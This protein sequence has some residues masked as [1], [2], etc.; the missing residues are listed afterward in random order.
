M[1]TGSTYRRKE[2][3]RVQTA[4]QYVGD[5]EEHGPNSTHLEGIP[6]GFSGG[7]LLS[8]SKIQKRLV[9]NPF[10]AIV[11]TGQAEFCVD[12]FH[13]GRPLFV[14]F[15]VRCVCFN[16]Q[17]VPQMMDVQSGCAKDAGCGWFKMALHRRIFLLQFAL[18]VLRTK[19][20][21]SSPVSTAHTPRMVP[22][23]FCRQGQS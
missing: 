2:Q 19:A 16:K 4:F 6:K 11:L 3:G 10:E 17:S 14:V 22:R 23:V 1:T 12:R 8:I 15:F 9:S 18:R 5:L 13:Q 7:R 20:G 21:H